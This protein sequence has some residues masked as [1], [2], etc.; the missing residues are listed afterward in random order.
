MDKTLFVIIIPQIVALL[1]VGLTFLFNHLNKNR[2]L[3]HDE[4]L[5]K[6]ELEQR[7]KERKF[8]VEQKMIEK[9]IEAHQNAWGLVLRLLGLVDEYLG[10]GKDRPIP[11]C[12]QREL[13]K[14]LKEL[15]DFN[16]SEG[17]FL[18]KRIRQQI[19]GITLVLIHKLTPGEKPDLSGTAIS[20]EILKTAEWLLTALEA[21]LKE[22]NPLYDLGIELP[23]LDAPENQSKERSK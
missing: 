10:I 23:G 7:E 3:K 22:Y 12:A 15:G 14:L 11:D 18:E 9:S 20:K 4:H 17:F 8:I 16:L 19:E 21:I 2:E 6:L 5:K 13:Y 1:I